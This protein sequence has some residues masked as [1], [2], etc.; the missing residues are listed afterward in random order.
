M[1]GK[2]KGTVDEVGEDHCVIDVHGVGYVAYCSV[3]T[4][5][6]LPGPG[7]AAVLFVETYVRED[8]IRLYGFRTALEREWFR[9]LQNNVQGVGAKVAL[10]V[11][12]TLAPGELANAIALRDIATV[13]RAPGVGRKVAERIVTELKNKAPALAG[14]GAANIG[15]K[16]DLGEGV[17]PAPV[18]DAVSALTNLGYSRDIAA[19]AVAAALKAAGEDADSAKL[20]RLGLKELAR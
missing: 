4:L 6:A 1:I 8:A 12:S 19:N 17:A 18:A 20:I 3:K 7:E 16:Q 15:L 13:A 2:L 9:L 14:D 10:G 5:A 11:L